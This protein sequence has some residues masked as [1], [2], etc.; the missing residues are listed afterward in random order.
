MI[1][2]RFSF[3]TAA[4]SAAAL[5]L[6][7]CAT[8]YENRIQSNLVQAGLSPRVSRCVAERMVDKLSGSE[9]RSLARIGRT[10]GRRIGDM[11]IAQFLRTYRTALDPHV[12]SVLTRAG[13]GCAIAG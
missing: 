10:S 7:G 2:A 6:S 5:A 8:T 9:L 4:A 3:L 11:T 12:F 13:L 1:R